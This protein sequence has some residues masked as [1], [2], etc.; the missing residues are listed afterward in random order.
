MLN[1]MRISVIIFSVFTL[2]ALPAAASG[3]AIDARQVEAGS[4]SMVAANPQRTSWSPEEVRGRLQ[5][6]WYKPIEPYISQ[7]VQIIASN[8]TLYISTAKGLF[9]LNAA[10]GAERWVYPTEFPL[11]HS[12]T[13]YNNTAYVGG[14]DHKLHAIDAVTGA[15]LWTFEAGAGFQTNPLVA[16]GK[17]F[18][19]N[20]DGFFYAVHAE[21]GSTGQQAWRY[22]VGFPILQSAAYQAGVLFFAAEDGHAY[23]LN[24]ATGALVWKSAK[25]PGA[26]FQSWWP[27]VHGDRVIF[28]GSN[29]YR[30]S[31]TPGGGGQFSNDLEKEDVYPNYATDPRGT[32]IGN[33]NTSPGPWAAGTPTIDASRILNYFS[34]KPWRKSVFVL[35]RTTGVEEETAP[36]LW[37]GTHSGSRYPPVVGSDNVLYQQNNYMSDPFIAGGQ[38]AGWSPG[39]PYITVVNSDWAA[40]DEPHAASAGGN[41]VYWSL[42]CDRQAG[43]FDITIPNTRFLD[44]WNAGILPPTGGT[45]G[46]DRAWGYFGYNLDSLLPGYNALYHNPRADYTSPYAYFIGTTGSHNGKY[47]FHGDTNA[48][49]PYK[50]KVYLHRGNTINCLRCIRQ[51]PGRSADSSDGCG[52]RYGSYPGRRSP[53]GRARPRDPAHA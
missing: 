49:I 40:V 48:P 30:T 25:L 17:V 37:T 36:V 15:G 4:W 12:P 24:A 51:Q 9:A 45:G 18:A 32:L 38:V 21:G 44:R 34:A 19:G 27:V 5:P 26:G 39:I 22:E 6:V 29:N 20:R 16:E 43:A 1:N 7:K 41:L 31:L 23:A 52:R 42:C 2:F 11:G 33:M 14:F 35:N 10:T 8:D 3:L 13:I 47:G 46:P 53:Q 28:S 50:G